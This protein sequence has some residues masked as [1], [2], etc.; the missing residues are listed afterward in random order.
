MSSADY[1]D[2][3]LQVK[4]IGDFYPALSDDALFVLW[5]LR[6][7]I[8]D[9]LDD[10]AKALTGGSGDKGVDAVLIDDRARSSYIVQ[11]KYRQK[12]LGSAEGRPEVMSFAELANYIYGDTANFK[13]LTKGM[14]QFARDRLAEARERALKRDY[15]TNLALVTL[16]TCSE[17][18]SKE[19]QRRVR[20]ISPKANIEILDGNRVMS[21]LS[22]YLGGVA[23]PVRSLNLPME[24]GGALYRFDSDSGIESWVFSMSGEDVASLFDQA[25]DRIFARNI[26]G[27]LGDTAINEH[28]KSTLADEP[29]QFWYYNNGVTIVCD[30]AQKTQEAGQE[31][32][33][34]SNPQ[35]INGQQTTRSLHAAIKDAPKADVLVKVIKI[36]RQAQDAKHSYEMLV[37]RI[38]EAT[39]YQNPIKPADLRANDPQ[40][41]TIE[42]ELRKLGYQYLRKR[43]TKREAKR[44]F[45][46]Q[47]TFQVSKEELAKAVGACK[48]ESLPRRV[49]QQK[50]FAD[51]YEEIFANHDAYF[52][53][54]CFWVSSLVD[55]ESWGSS[56]RQWAKYIALYFLWKDIFPSI[57]PRQR[58]FVEAAE[59]H[60]KGND[61]TDPLKVAIGT[62]LEAA[63][64]FYRRERGKG[65]DRVELSPFFKRKGVYEDFL[66]Y[67]ES[68]S[69]TLQKKYTRARSKFEIALKR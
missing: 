15:R 16:G 50:L 3:Q 28:M 13:S 41:I 21:L 32:L 61:I 22:D 65:S 42:R 27:F 40:Q 25:R 18:L 14:D 43:Q 56:E 5:F 45:G 34:V 19:A 67:W 30:E 64:R 47:H 39:N 52:Y 63:V 1:E 69:N 10:A 8:A 55:S 9:E 48:F 31:L 11:G 33:N 26:R 46:A 57:K 62:L 29:Q 36:P 38:V 6:A 68:P 7:Y 4:E 20:A 54:S 24:H 49:G 23:P 51:H 44:A 17:D 37:A 12:L 60:K 2:M 35:I 59:T 53:L 58:D 66:R